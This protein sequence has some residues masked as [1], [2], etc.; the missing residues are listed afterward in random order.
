VGFEKLLVQMII[1][2]LMIGCVFSLIA[3]GLTIIWGVMNIINF[4]HGEFLMIGMFISFLF[5]TY[6]GID[7]LFSLPVV[8]IILFFLGLIT[9][10]VLIKKVLKG[11]VLAQLVVTF[12][13]SIFLVHLAVFLWTADYKMIQN[14]IATGKISISGIFISIP[15]LVASIGSLIISAVVYWFIKKTKTGMAIEA[16]SMDKD[17]AALMGINTD[18]LYALSFAVGIMCVGVAGGLLS[19]FYYI[20]PEV[21]FFFGVIAFATVALGGFGSIEGAMI[22]GILVGLAE[23][24]GGFFLAPAYKY[25]VVFAIYIG[26]VLIKPT[27]LK[28]W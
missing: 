9:Y 18:R 17:A 27:G 7:P 16:I 26:V 11:P 14:P 1:S 2:G 24:L 12:G 10:R 4:A 19:N 28:G 8:A 6:W 15:E 13:L 25:A 23:I 5:A 21:G 3:I 22:A 20:F